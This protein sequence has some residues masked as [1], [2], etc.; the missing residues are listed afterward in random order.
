MLLLLRSNRRLIPF[1]WRALE[2]GVHSG[3]ES[4]KL[5]LLNCCRLC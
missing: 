3:K 5:S 2:G 1:F 4:S